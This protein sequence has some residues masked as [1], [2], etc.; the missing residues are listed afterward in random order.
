MVSSVSPTMAE[1]TVNVTTRSAVSPMQFAV[2]DTVWSPMPVGV[3]DTFP[4]ASS[5]PSGSCVPAFTVQ[6]TSPMSES[7]MGEKSMLVPAMMSLIVPLTLRPSTTVNC[8][9]W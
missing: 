5:R 2:S 6:V 8:T 1:Y 3:P 7:A 4:S 9:Y